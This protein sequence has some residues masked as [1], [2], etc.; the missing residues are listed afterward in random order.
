MRDCSW[1]YSFIRI[2]YF[3]CSH[4]AADS[5]CIV[6]LLGDNLSSFCSESSHSNDEIWRRSYFNS[7][8]SNHKDLC[9]SN[10]RAAWMMISNAYFFSN[11]NDLRASYRHIP[12]CFCCS[13]FTSSFSRA[14]PKW[15]SCIHRKSPG[16]ISSANPYGLPFSDIGLSI[17]GVKILAI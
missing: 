10:S 5:S 17:S 11:D 1:I 9:F 12:L 13:S 4:I 8:C 3:Q 6:L 7:W 14:G 2:C 16:Q 15:S